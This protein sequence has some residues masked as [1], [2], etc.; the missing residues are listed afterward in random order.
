VGA[1]REIENKIRRGG[2]ILKEREKNREEK[3]KIT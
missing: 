2:E 1:K 3:E